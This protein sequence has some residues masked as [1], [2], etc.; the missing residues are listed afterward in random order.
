MCTATYVR[1][2]G[3]LRR[4]RLHVQPE[5]ARLAKRLT[6]LR[7]AQAL[8]VEAVA[9]F[10]SISALTLSA[11]E[12]GRL[13]D[14]PISYVLGLAAALGVSLPELFADGEPSELV[15]PA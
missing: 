1:R 9:Q 5:L 14:P 8:S 3:R 6:Q 13:A 11:I 4:F 15:S 12:A 7:L 2:R 10:A